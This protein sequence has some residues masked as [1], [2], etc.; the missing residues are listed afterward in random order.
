MKE[1]L[2]PRSCLLVLGF[3]LVTAVPA[4]AGNITYTCDASITADG[5]ALCNYLNSTIAGLYGSTFTNAT[6]N[7]YIQY[8]STSL[9]E[10]SQA[11]ELATYSQYLT[12][13]R[14]ESTDS[15]ALSSLPSTEPSIFTG[16]NIGLTSALASALG[17]T[18]V[19]GITAPTVAGTNTGELNCTIGT[20]GCY[21]G[22]VTISNSA[23]LWYRSLSGGSEPGGDYDFFSVVE[24]ETDEMLGTISCIATTDGLFNQCGGTNEAQNNDA[25]AIDLFRYSASGQ[26][27]FDD[28]AA[29][30]FS[31]NGGVTDT[32]GNQYNH[33]ANGLDY[34]DFSSNC[35]FVQDATGCQGVSLDIT[36]DGGGKAGPE[37]AMLNA[38]GYDL[39]TPEP[40][41]LLLF[42]SGLLGLGARLRR[43]KIIG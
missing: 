6:A 26:R 15:T 17:F 10:S 14:A 9:G 20:T 36:T 34:A 33:A 3:V 42:A 39:T 8:G 1:F 31:P 30:Y 11:I 37:V 25:S 12:K 28:T 29:A 7:I 18:G 4:F 5:P 21:N 38:V 27:D 24:H 2:M 13:L 40:A 19:Q 43:K 16:G 22:V 32:D 41:S 35:T 23:A